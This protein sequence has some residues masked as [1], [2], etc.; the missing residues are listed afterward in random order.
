MLFIFLKNKER[1]EYYGYIGI[2]INP[3]VNKYRIIRT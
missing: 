3:P 2:E 1:I